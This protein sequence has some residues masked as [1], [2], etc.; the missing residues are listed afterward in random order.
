M[1]SSSS[2]RRRQR[3]LQQRLV[4]SYQTR[5]YS[6]R[7]PRASNVVV[8]AASAWTIVKGVTAAAFVKKRRGARGQVR[9][10]PRK[11]VTSELFIAFS[12]LG[13]AREALEI[14]FNTTEL[15]CAYRHGG[16]R[17]RCG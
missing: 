10:G 4:L 3:K 12:L 2:S 1:W 17:M 6:F 8:V 11:T 14:V 16:G 5:F 13:N 9:R 15:T 7:R